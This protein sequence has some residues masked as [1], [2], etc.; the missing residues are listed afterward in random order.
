MTSRRTPTTSKS[1]CGATTWTQRWP[2]AGKASRCIGRFSGR[3]HHRAD[4]TWSLVH[5]VNAKEFHFFPA[6]EGDPP[7]P[8]PGINEERPDQ[9]YWADGTGPAV[10]LET[11][12]RPRA[13]G[14]TD[15]QAG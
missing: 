14:P 6:G 10:R 8:D 4:D 7:E 5:V 3:E 11:A 1:T 15:Q 9:G 12:R 2:T 13:T